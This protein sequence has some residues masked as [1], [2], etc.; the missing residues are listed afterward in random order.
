MTRHLLTI[1]ALSDEDLAELYALARSPFDDELL[2]GQGVALVFERPSLRT[3]ASS[4][5]AVAELG[6]FA[7]FFGDDEIGLDT[8]ESAEDVARTLNETFAI[9]AMRLRRHEV[10]HRMRVATRDELSLVNLLSSDAHPTQALADVLTLADEFSDGDVYG[11]AGLRVAYVGD[12]TNVTRSLA[13]ALTRLGV[14]VR[15]GAPYQYQ[16]KESGAENPFAGGERGSLELFDSAEAAVEGVDAVYT[17]AWVSMGFESEA[18]Q[19]RLDLAA[20]RVDDRLLA[21]ASSHAIVMHC[22]P[23]HRGDEI[24]SEVLDSPRSRVWRQVF[25]RRSAMRAA[26]RWIKGDA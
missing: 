8:R 6:G 24:V 5:A 4:A 22:L 13:V 7:T 15:V 2:K 19:R 14:H 21:N 12:A 11:M 26:L 10:F 3:R 16:L 1:E 17:D 9:A 18:A 20:F 25:H 23:A